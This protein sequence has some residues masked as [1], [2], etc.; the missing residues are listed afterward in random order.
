MHAGKDAR[1]APDGTD[2]LEGAAVGADALVQDLGADLLFGE[3]IQAVLHLPLFAGIDVRKVREDVLFDLVLLLFARG[4]VELFEGGVQLRGRIGA[5]R[6]VDVFR[7][8]VQLHL[9]LGL[10]DLLL[11]ALDEGAQLLDLFMAEEDR[12]D[13]LLVGDFLRPRLDH[14][15]RVLRTGKAEGEAALFALSVVGIDDIL[16]VHH[17][18]LHGAGRTGPGDV[19][20]AQRDRAAEHRERFGRDVRVDG[21]R[22]RDDHDVVE[23]AL[24]EERTDR[25]VDETGGE[26]PLIARTPFALFEAARDLA[27]RV[28]LLFEVDL[29]REE[30]HPVARLIGHGYVDH[31]HRVAAA[32]H[33]RAVRLL[34]V[35]ARFDD[36]LSAADF[37]FK[38]SEIF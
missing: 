37:R 12:A 34:G 32:H 16:A 4:A 8:V 36:D 17:A 33:A 19:G 18:D 24:R 11:D 23:Q 2:L 13:H 28:H 25:A 29:Q 22:G 6:R 20:N 27:D 1:F 35:L 14:H 10:A 38:L 7:N 31:D 26:D 30:I 5:D 9:T 21:E 3:V 15:D